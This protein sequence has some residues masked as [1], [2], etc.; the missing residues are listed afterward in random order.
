VIEEIV[1]TKGVDTRTEK[2]RDTVRRTDVD[3]E[4]LGSKF[5]ESQYQ[6]HFSSELAKDKDYDFSSYRPAYKFGH[7]MR[8]DDRF[9]GD[10]WN[11]VETNARQTWE[12]KN[13]GTWE[14][15]KGAVKHAW[16]RAKGG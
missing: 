7:D 2:V 12:E 15:F 3:V 10:A 14:R 9:S 13:P 1:I 11:K 8:G 5:D 16:E 4:Q 6:E